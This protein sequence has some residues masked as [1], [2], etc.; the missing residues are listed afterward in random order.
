[1]KL[2]YKH[3]TIGNIFCVEQIQEYAAV[4]LVWLLHAGYITVNIL[5]SKFYV[6][7]STES[8]S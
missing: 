8:N 7:H 5:L 1:M 2:R 6:C 3:N 4:V